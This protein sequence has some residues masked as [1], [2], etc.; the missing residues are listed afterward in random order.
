M[1]L[2]WQ[3]P[4]SQR[5]GVRERAEGLALHQA[6][7]LPLLEVS[8]TLRAGR[9]LHPLNDLRARLGRYITYG[10]IARMFAGAG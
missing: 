5:T 8:Q 2:P 7:L 3:F 6:F 9:V 4:G 1:G 10:I